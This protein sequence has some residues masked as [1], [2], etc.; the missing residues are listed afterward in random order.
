L[1]DAD[2]AMY[3]AKALGKAR[4]EVFDPALRM[5]T[6]TRLEL[7]NH[8]GNVGNGDFALL[9]MASHEEKLH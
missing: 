6:F 8:L 7:E 1:R 3:H 9:T 2:T 5:D 4:C